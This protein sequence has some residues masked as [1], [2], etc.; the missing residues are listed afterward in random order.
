MEGGNINGPNY[1]H[2]TTC[3]FLV[4]RIKIYSFL[5]YQGI[6][7]NLALQWLHNERD[8]VSNH[9]GINCLFNR[10]CR[11]RSMKASK[12]RVTGLY[13]RNPPVTGG[14]PSQRASYTENVSIWWHHHDH[15]IQGAWT[16]WLTHSFK[17]ILKNTNTMCVL[18]LA[19][20]V[21]TT[22]LIPSQVSSQSNSSSETK[23]RYYDKTKISS[24]P[25]PEFVIFTTGG[26]AND[27]NH[28]AG[29]EDCVP[30]YQIRI[31]DAQ[32]CIDLS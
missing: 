31:S 21:E 28:V 4:D 29:C 3:H 30:A 1:D 18:V 22:S 27:K 6:S 12:L 14:F 19:V 13:E 15:Y 5:K 23:C 20:I 32:S 26:T 7:L 9:L 2:R 24:L 17:C 16:R 11:S 8:G 10:F 25:V